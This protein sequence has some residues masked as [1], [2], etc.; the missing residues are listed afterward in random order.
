MNRE[1]DLQHLTDLSWRRPLTP[2]EAARLKA[3]LGD[4]PA[5]DERIALE[6]AL[7][8]ALQRLPDVPVAGNFTARVLQEAAREDRRTET[9]APAGAWWR[10]WLPRAAVAA[11]VAGTGL[12]SWNRV[13]THRRAEMAES[14]ATV[15]E[16]SSLPSPEI[17]KDFEAIRALT[18]S[19]RADEEL[20]ALLQ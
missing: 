2:E 10:R 11:V 5:A 18:P 15:A 6:N 8:R 20:L 19:P 13:E 4:E 1:P 7:S 14:V 12:I 3:A 17:L 9:R 16:V